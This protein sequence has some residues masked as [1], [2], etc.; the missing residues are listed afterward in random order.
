MENRTKA[1]KYITGGVTFPRQFFTP[2]DFA[3]FD[4]ANDAIFLHDARS[5][6]VININKKA[7]ELYGYSPEDS[8][9]LTLAA[10][11]PCEFP[12][13]AEEALPR[14]QRAA[15]GEAQLVEWKT[16]TRTGREIWFEI[17]LKLIGIHNHE[18]V[19]AIARDITRKKL[20]E[21]RLQIQNNYSTL[22]QETSL[23][24][25]NRLDLNDL[26][27]TL[28]SH[29]G[30]LLGTNHGF[31][32]LANS[33]TT[34]LELKV[35]TSLQ[36]TFLSPRVKPGETLAGKVWQTGEPMVVQNYATWSDRSPSTPEYVRAM[37]GAPLK[38]DSQVVGV[39]GLC[40]LDEEYLFRD[41]EI[42]L[43]SRFA[44]LASIALDNARL[45]TTAHSELTERRRAE[46]ALQTSEE[47]HR[48]LFNSVHDA[49]YVT[50]IT[51]DGLPGRIIEANDTACHL[52]GYS[53]DELLR[54]TTADIVPLEHRGDAQERMAMLHNEK[55][56]L[57]E[58]VHIP[59]EGSDIPVEI[60]SHLLSL[61]NQP[62][63]LSI[64]RDITE[65]I[66]SEKEIARLDR[67]NLIGAMAAGIGHEI[68]NPLT[69]V[70]GFLQM[71]TSKE[72]CLPHREY[73]ELMVQ[74][75]DR[76]NSI[77]TE[78]LSLAKNKSIDLRHGNLNTIVNIVLPL[79]EAGAI[80]YDKTVKTDLAEIV[81]TPMDEKEIRQ[82]VL[83][84]VRNGLDA[85]PPGGILTIRT[86]ATDKEVILSVQDQGKGIPPDVADKIGTPFF[87]TKEYGVGLGLAVCYSIAA[88]HNA[89]ITFDSGPT[90][91]TFSVHFRLR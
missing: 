34:L 7:C 69:T 76:A 53:R 59:K 4:Q 24:I 56:V 52:L 21:Q 48:V 11:Y 2:V 3:V 88:R 60:N 72:E 55:H 41:D 1:K 61:D 26:L 37:I 22:L 78:F 64:V 27:T 46:A 16:K 87:T 32:Y 63:I 29:A 31:I 5:G 58:S 82:L 23:A 84:L 33:E 38:S 86:A 10:L 43:F 42:A 90:G 80:L 75:L 68:R 9:T 30:T 70:R 74:E 79:L 49:I 20:T 57:I 51:P 13:S 54:L 36:D 67:L 77:I 71:L 19:L 28:V 62:C 91:T 89:S 45:Y 14:I 39:I 40:Y 66:R 83:N 50:E 25:M 8:R 47:R 85:M 12:Y 73:F 65:R 18:M 81:E 15:A 44:E 6:A 17:S 35:S